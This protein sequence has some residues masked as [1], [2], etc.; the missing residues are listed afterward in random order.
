MCIDQFAEISKALL[1]PVIA[2]VATYIAWQQWKTNQQKLIL[3]RYDR[4]L[5]VY[6]DV[7]QILSLVCQDGKASNDDLLK[8]HRAVSEADFLFGSE[9]PAY[10]DEMKFHR[11]VSEADFLFGSEIPAYI[12]EI[13]QRGVKLQYWSGQYRDFTQIQPDGYDHKNVCDRAST[14]LTWLMGQ[15]EPAKQKFKKYLDIS[16]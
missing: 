16:H 6:E 5:K 10:I 9:I 3:D 14:E 8:F 13:Y 12:D 11:A 1:T 2:I 7:R 4:R 15:F